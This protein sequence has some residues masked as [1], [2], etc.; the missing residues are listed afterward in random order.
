MK[1]I[2]N[3]LNSHF[4]MTPN[5]RFI[6]SWTPSLFHI[7]FFFFSCLY[8]W[9]KFVQDLSMLTMSVNQHLHSR[10]QEVKQLKN[11]IITQ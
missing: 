4:I 7:L 9:V 10:R 1:S 11:I 3:K 8:M 6:L 2:L 5:E